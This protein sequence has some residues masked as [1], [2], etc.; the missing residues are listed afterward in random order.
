[1]GWAGGA[2]KKRP[3]QMSDTESKRTRKLE[4]DE[5]L[6]RSTYPVA[7]VGAVVLDPLFCSSES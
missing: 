3:K 2:T 1:M 6:S 5:D 7:A 4:N